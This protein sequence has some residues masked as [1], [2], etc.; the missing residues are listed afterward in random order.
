MCGICGLGWKDERLIKRM[1]K[2]LNHRGPDGHGTWTAPGASLGHTR[3]AIIDLS[4]RGAQPMRR[5]NL[6]IT[7]NGEI[8]NY[9]AI[10]EELEAA[11]KKFTSGSDTEVLLAA[12]ER[13]DE[14]MLDRLNGMFAFCIYDRKKR[15]LFLA[16][17]RFGI[18]P[19]YYTQTSKG[20]AFASEISSLREVM[21]KSAIEENGLRQFFTFRFTLGETTML[22][23]VKKLLPG[24]WMRVKPASKKT[25]IKRWYQLKEQPLQDRPFSWWKRELRCHVEK[26]VERRMVADVPVSAFLS[27]GIDSSVITLLAKRH[28]EAL[29]TFSMGFDTTNELRYA[30]TVAKSVWTNHRELTLDKETILQHLDGMVAHMDEPIGDPGFLPVYVLSK[31]V[32]K[33]N[34]VVL[35][36]DGGD[37]IL[38]GYDRYKLLKHGWHLR[39]MAFTDFGSDIGAR[40]KAMR[41]KD[42]YGA[43]LEIIRLFDTEELERLGVKEWDARPWW[44]EAIG[45]TKVERAQSFDILTLLP[46]DFFMKADKMSSA[47]GLEQ[48]VPF[49]DHELV[50]FA[51]SMPLKHKLQVWNEKKALKK[52]FKNDLPRAIIKRHKHGFNVPIDHWFKTT[53]GKRLR[54]LL[55]KSDHGLYDKKYA[56][57]LLK[58]MKSKGTNYKENFMIAQKLWSILV[59]ELWYAQWKV[60]G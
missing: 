53:L 28:N 3:L 34:K 40:L 48:R 51:F 7:F 52:A 1:T 8:Y 15:E 35:S 11:G 20:I 33:H 57:E 9:K 17:D 12:Y 54:E 24:H 10:K 39:G 16:R 38:T 56:L 21:G 37:E 30:Q 42:E 46:G 23:D 4:K 22:K 55:K 18:K 60:K 44:K 41:G 27:G 25:E 6:T 13:W 43:F 31:E 19:L 45:R 32:A 36:G 47:W 59:F 5:G 2:K 29:N 26:A 49:M 58:R 14:G 50:E